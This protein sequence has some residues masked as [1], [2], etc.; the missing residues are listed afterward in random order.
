MAVTWL[1]SKGMMVPTGRT[2]PPQRINAMLNTFFGLLANEPPAVAETFIKDKT[3][4]WLFTRLALKAALVNPALLLWIWD[5]AGTKDLIRWLGSYLEFTIDAL[6]N[7]CFASW[8]PQWLKNSQTWLEKSYPSLWLKMLG[9]SQ[10]LT[11]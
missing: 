11:K 5:M 1:F 2:L 4:W 7:L 10:N 8:F 3:T 9:L 6:R